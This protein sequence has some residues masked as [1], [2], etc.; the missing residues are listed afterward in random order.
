MELGFSSYTGTEFLL[1]YTVLLVIAGIAAWWLPNRFRPDG[2]GAQPEHAELLAYLGGGPVRFVDT[3][4]ASLIARNGMKVSDKFFVRQGEAVGETRAEN[5]VLRMVGALSYGQSRDVLREHADAAERDL[6]QKG[7]LMDDDERTRLRMLGLAPLLL[8]FGVG[9]YRWL[10]GSAQG[11]PVAFLTVLLGLT[12]L[13]AAIRLFRINPRTRAGDEALTSAKEKLARLRAAP[14]QSEAGLA[15]GLFGTA[16][17]IGTP[18]DELHAMRQS[19]A[20][21]GADS[22]NGGDGGGDGGSG[23][24]GGGCGGCGG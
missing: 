1:L 18:Y 3:V 17:L 21:S 19:A 4:L 15:V 12:V 11:E 2:R 20:G 14:R 10:A 22:S 13:L 24:G 8:L 23:C 9:L 5:A 6:V 16:V 7:L